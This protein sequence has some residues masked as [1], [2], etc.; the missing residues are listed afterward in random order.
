V[1]DLARTQ[2]QEND[3]TG[4]RLGSKTHHELYFVWEAMIDRCRNSHHEFWRSYGGRGIRVCH[5]WLDKKNGFG[6]FLADMGERPPGRDHNGKALFSLDRR[7]NDGNYEP[8]N[9]K[10]STA[11]EQ[12][13][14]KRSRKRI[15]PFPGYSQDLLTSL[16]ASKALPWC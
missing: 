3:M 4:P 7:N 9:C 1:F 2:Y 5:R 6:N 14:N 15:D 13:K 11:S 10:W 12:Q 8:N 16:A